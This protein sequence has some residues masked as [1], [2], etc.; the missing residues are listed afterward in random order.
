MNIVKNTKK[1]TLA[2]LKSFAKR[3]EGNIFFKVKSDFDGM[4]DC[5]QSVK[6]DWRKTSIK[7]PGYYRTGIEG[8]YTV[9]RSRDYFNIY[10]DDE[11]FGI[12]V[13]NSCGSS[14]LATK[15]QAEYID[16]ESEILNDKKT[17]T[18]TTQQK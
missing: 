15:K 11:Y 18:W 1:I 3:N 5:V 16:F 10:E 13:Y 9:G 12:R 7:E 17:I 14:I 6:M 8:V 2:T 4:T